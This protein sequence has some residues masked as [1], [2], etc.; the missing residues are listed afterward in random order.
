MAAAA[1]SG[2]NATSKQNIQTEG[3]EWA[4]RR[5]GTGRPTR[6]ARTNSQAGRETGKNHVLSLADRYEDWRSFPV[7]PYSAIY[8]GLQAYIPACI[9]SARRA[10]G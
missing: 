9:T 5:R 10:T 3:G 2:R 6:L 7:D 4:G 1:E 8:D